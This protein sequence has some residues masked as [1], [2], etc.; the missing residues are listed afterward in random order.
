[1]ASGVKYQHLLLWKDANATTVR[2]I[3]INEWAQSKLTGDDLTNFNTWHTAQVAAEQALIDAGRLTKEII[4]V[5]ADGNNIP[6]CYK[7]TFTDWDGDSGVIQTDALEE[8]YSRAKL[9]G[10]DNDW[11]ADYE[12][13]VLGF[14]GYFQDGTPG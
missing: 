8:W 14:M 12:G 4:T 6:A 9:E 11:S 2:S 1:M 7:L 5:D 3:E 13:I 10:E